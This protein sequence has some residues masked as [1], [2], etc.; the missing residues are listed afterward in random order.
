MAVP[1]SPLPPPSLRRVRD[2]EVVS[3]GFSFF[4]PYF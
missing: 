2:L 1:V 3:S 4:V